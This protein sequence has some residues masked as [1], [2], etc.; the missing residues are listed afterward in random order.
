MCGIA[1]ACHFDGPP[2][3]PS[4]LTRMIDRL[5]H[6][7]PDDSGYRMVDHVGLGNRRLKIL[8]LSSAGHQPMTTDDGRLSVTFNGEI[9]NYVELKDELLR[10]GHRFRSHTDTEVVLHSFAEWGTGSTTRA[11]ARSCSRAIGGA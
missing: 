1:G 3:D 2:I 5:A 8:D 6:R 4:V 9:Y 7:G 10:R 11:I